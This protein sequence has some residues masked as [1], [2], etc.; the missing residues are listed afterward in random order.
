VAV[1]AAVRFVED[2]AVGESAERTV[3]V[4]EAD[5]QAFAAVSGDTNPLHLDEAFAQA[6]PFKGRIAH[7]MLSA[8]YISA[9]LGTELPGPGAVYVS[10]TLT[11]KRPVRV[12]DALTV[13]VEVKA[14]DAAAGRI[15]LSTVCSLGRK[16]AV[17]GEAEV[18]FPR[19]PAR[20]GAA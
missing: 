13:R 20:S 11:F 7:G 6:T 1:Q 8:A 19:R 10:Q 9:V 15:T 2:V 4:R 14:V 3:V 5:L 18:S 12:G 17:V 16:A